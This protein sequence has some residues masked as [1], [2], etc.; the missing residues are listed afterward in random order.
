[1]ILSF[2]IFFVVLMAAP[3]SVTTMQ[4]ATPA[5]ITAP[6]QAAT[7]SSRVLVL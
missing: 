4:L 7:D 5:S 3:F 6:Q 1:M 2:F